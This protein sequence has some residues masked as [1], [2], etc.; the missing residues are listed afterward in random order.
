MKVI[1]VYVAVEF[2]EYVIQQFKDGGFDYY[3]LHPKVLGF[4]CQDMSPL[5]D[6]HIFPGYMVKLE[7]CC[8]DDKLNEVKTISANLHKKLQGKA[9]RI[10]VKSVEEL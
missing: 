10:F 5:L 3:I 7:F 4:A 8:S 2:G 9:L 6:S 1:E